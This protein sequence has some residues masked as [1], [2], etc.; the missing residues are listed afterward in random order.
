VDGLVSV[1]VLS[2]GGL[3]SLGDDSVFA[4]AFLVFGAPS[5]LSELDLS[6][7]DGSSALAIPLPSPTATHEDNKNAATISRNHQ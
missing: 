6:E 7:G 2:A 1:V 4:S 3:L 5:E